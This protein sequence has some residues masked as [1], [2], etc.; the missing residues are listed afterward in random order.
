MGHCSDRASVG[1]SQIRNRTI[2]F[3][4]ADGLLLGEGK[5]GSCINFER[6]LLFTNSDN[7]HSLA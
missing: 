6:N 7:A 5:L 1:R 3:Q 2:T 4:R